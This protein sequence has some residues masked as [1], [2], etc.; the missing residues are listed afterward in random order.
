MTA[1]AASDSPLFRYPAFD[2]DTANDSP[3]FRP[4]LNQLLT[5]AAGLL[6]PFSAKDSLALDLTG[7]DFRLGLRV[8]LILHC[9]Q[10]SATDSWI[11]P[12]GLRQGPATPLF[13]FLSY[14]GC[15]GCLR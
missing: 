1:H 2:A 8:L 10:K 3:V 14:R 15:V 13:E 6:P 12:V 5:D 4:G 11:D 7:I 9:R